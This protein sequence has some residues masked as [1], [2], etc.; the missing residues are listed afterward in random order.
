MNQQLLK[1]LL[2][3]IPIIALIWVMG[4]QIADDQKLEFE[5]P[6]FEQAIRTELQLE[7]GVIRKDLLNRVEQLSLANYSISSIEG[8]Q[9]FESLA[10]LDISGN[11]II[12]LK[13]LERMSRL[14]NLIVRDNNVTTLEPLTAL[15]AITSLNVRGNKIETLE[16]IADL[17]NL[18]SLNIRENQ[19]KDLTPLGNLV[20]LIDL[21]AR[22]NNITSVEALATLPNLRER[23]YLEGNPI[24]D[25]TLLSQAYD[26]IKD[27]DF[28]RPEHHLVFSDLGGL[29]DSS[30][31]L[32]LYTEGEAEGTIRY[33]TD[34]SV[35][36]ETSTAYSDP[37]T[38][39]KSMVVRAK[40]F[41][42]GLEEGEEITHSYLIGVETTLPIVSISTDPANL[43]DREIGIYV[44][45]IYYNPD[46]PNPQHTGNFAQSGAEWERPI[47]L[48]FFEENGERV[49]SQG[50][51]IRIHGGASRTVDRK[52]FRL[53][54]RSDYGE[55]RFRYP[56]FEEDTRSEYNRLLL[57]NSG[58][59]WNNTL[60]R[61][62]LLQT[63]IRDFDLET[64][65]YRPS[66]LYVNGE[67]WGIYNIRE[68]YDSHYY[69]IKHG[70]DPQNLD[71]LERD[72]TVIEG[73][74]DDYVAL[75]L[76]MEENN[77]SKPD[78]YEEIANQMDINNFIDYQIAQIF[79]RNTDWPG[80]NNR[81][82]RERPDGK[83]RWSVFDLDFGFDLPNATGTV[84]HDT[85]SFATEPGG[86]S[87]PNPDYSTFLLRTLLQNE[88]F[89]D[90]FI[91]RFAHYLNTNFES[92]HVIQ[93]ID[94]MAAALAPEM[95]NH[96]S[97]WGTPESLEKWEEEVE[98]MRR[99]ADRRPDFVQAHLLSFFQLRGIG[100]MT[101]DKVQDGLTWEFAGRD[102]SKLPI[103]WN[104]TYVTDT[105]IAI[106]FPELNHVQIESSDDSVVE[107]T[108]GKLVLKDE[109]SARVHFSEGNDI[110]LELTFNVTHIEQNDVTLELG[111]TLNIAAEHV[112]Y[113]ETSNAD[114]ATISENEILQINELGS[115]V[116]TGHTTDGQVIHLLNVSTHNITRT[117]GF[118]NA[119]SKIFTY[120][121]AWQQSRIDD[122]RDQLAI[123]SNETESDVT[124]T[125]E[126]T[127]FIWFGYSSTTQG[128]AEV[129]VNGELV[130]EVDTF[131]R[132]AIF[133]NKLFELTG[134]NYG[135]H[136]VT[137][138]VKGESRPEATNNRVHIDGVQ[139]LQ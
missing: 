129:Y 34:G 27:K 63:L 102:A 15:R 40:F 43:F 117:E 92:T 5:D 45:G 50:A 66:T 8:I 65:L 25:W 20:E 113:W 7:D 98:T 80:N 84:A 118:Y 115:A 78:V 108:E 46:A 60:F 52:S 33:T 126:G 23:L 93:T 85:L 11:K 96:I 62:A 74:N 97:R 87:W 101:I 47:H 35:P 37:I 82:W 51:G 53:Y 89:R 39:D 68:R 12:D 110:V 42:E 136:T 132:S 71:F 139:I 17:T 128:L 79:V 48:E 55:N 61:D 120:T 22:Y 100:D 44:P 111:D 134:L 1:H 73:T 107:V 75:R 21:N 6:A 112:A 9:A 91:S 18:L 3:L 59:D 125:F 130:A 83:W 119:D 19:V 58:N 56:F 133:Q 31:D 90:T 2:W 135:E 32:T 116:V 137:I 94:K 64:Q 77:V 28:P 88:S 70:V 54:A 13:P 121:G 131:N 49:L 109:G 138:S 4:F 67:Y 95:P 105:A 10:S 36:D 72:A 69:E 57:R 103:G 76:F 86:T 106:S 122:H 123:Y 26:S 30:I 124:F 29:Y 38:I 127:G 99:F 81:Y 104:G 16:P 14:E 24:T 114:I 41:A